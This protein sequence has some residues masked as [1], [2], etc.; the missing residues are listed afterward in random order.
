MTFIFSPQGA[1]QPGGKLYYRSCADIYEITK[2]VIA[3]SLGSHTN[4]GEAPARRVGK[5]RAHS[6]I[7]EPSVLDRDSKKALTHFGYM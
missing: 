1:L 3:K 5:W 4:Q 6:H 7:F 2:S